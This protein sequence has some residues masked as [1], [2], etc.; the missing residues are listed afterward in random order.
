MTF[1]ASDKPFAF[2]GSGAQLFQNLKTGED[3]DG[4][5]D[6]VCRVKLI[7]IETRA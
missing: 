7:Y 6:E 1:A 2:A 5:E 4:N 3:D